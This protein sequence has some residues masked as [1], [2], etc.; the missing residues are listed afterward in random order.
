MGRRGLEKVAVVYFFP[1]FTPL[2]VQE[3]EEEEAD[4]SVFFPLFWVSLPQSHVCAEWSVYCPPLPRAKKREIEKGKKAKGGAGR[5][6]EWREEE[7]EE[8]LFHFF[9]VPSP[10]PP[11]AG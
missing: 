4:P 2:R 6:K 7:E 3:M 1:F 9:F 5:G 11:F 8:A 10:F